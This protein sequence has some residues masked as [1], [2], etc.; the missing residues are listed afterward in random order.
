ME[1][2]R[3]DYSLQ[4]EAIE[5]MIFFWISVTVGELTILAV[6]LLCRFLGWVSF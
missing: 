2:N 1:P 6:A 4:K 5:F 3:S